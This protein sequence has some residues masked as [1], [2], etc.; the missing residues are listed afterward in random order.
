M[1]FCLQL[2]TL[3][4]LVPEFSTLENS[5]PDIVPGPLGALGDVCTGK[6][7]GQ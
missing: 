7:T 1:T 3:T 5:S 6:G 4:P 2:L